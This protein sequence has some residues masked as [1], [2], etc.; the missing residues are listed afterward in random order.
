MLIAAF[1]IV[2]RKGDYDEK[3]I[4]FNFNG[5]R[6][7]DDGDQLDEPVFRRYADRGFLGYFFVCHFQTKL[8]CS[9]PCF[10]F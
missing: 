10:I 5:D 8:F 1:F 2:K 7:H 4:E 9:K 3:V 6:Y